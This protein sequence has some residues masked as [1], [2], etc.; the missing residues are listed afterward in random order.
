MIGPSSN[1]NFQVPEHVNHVELRTSLK[2]RLRRFDI[3]AFDL[4]KKIGN[5]WAILTVA[6]LDNGRK[7]L[8]LYGARG[9]QPLTFGFI[10]LHCKMSNKK[11]DPRKVVTLLQKEEEI[12]SRRVQQPTAGASQPIFPFQTLMTGVWNYDQQGRLTFDQ[13]Y[14]D[15]RVGSVTFGRHAL[16]IYLETATVNGFDWHGR[17]D[18]PYAILEHTISFVEDAHRGS[19]TLTLKSPPKIYQI[20]GTEDLHLYTGRQ[21]TAAANGLPMLASLSLGAPNR[22]R[23]I[24]K[25]ERLCSLQTKHDSCPALCMVYKLVFPS[26]VINQVWAFL[27][28]FSVP[29]VHCRKTALWTFTS[30]IE[31]ELRSLEAALANSSLH[32]AEKFQ[33]LALVYEGTL[34]PR[35][36]QELI[37]SIEASSRT[38]G[39]KFTAL[40]VRNLGRQIPTPGPHVD[41]ADFQ[42]TNLRKALVDNVQDALKAELTHTTLHG[43][44]KQQ[45]HLALTYKATV[46]PTGKSQHLVRRDGF[47]TPDRSPV[48]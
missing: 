44:H 42:I 2:D 9:R 46:T 36:M 12:R 7:F 28:D 39:S 25:L 4:F 24:A 8:G 3:L 17:I 27:N 10:N 48:L 5:N 6:D 23:R 11:A 31:T 32:F 21:S 1:L 38:H 45:Q 40:A 47:V 14:R 41:S 22:G 43:K 13:K 30:A 35:R 34:T 20:V 29:E 18:I 15:L 37:S 19:I 26:A 16:V 33:V